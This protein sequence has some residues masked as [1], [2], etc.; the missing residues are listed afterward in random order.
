MNKTLLKNLALLTVSVG[1]ALVVAE[2]AAGMVF[3][4]ITTTTDNRS[5]FALKWKEAN[6]RRNSF[7]YREREF[8]PIKPAGT[9]R[10]AFIGDSYAFGQGIAETDRM[11]NLLEGELR[12]R[13]RSVEVLNF[14]EAGNNTADEV[15]VLQKVLTSVKPDFVLL[16]WF[17]NDTEGNGPTMP[18]AS[19]VTP[20]QPSRF[21]QFK[22]SMRN[23]SVLYFLAAEVWH[24]L[25]ETV[26]ANYAEGIVKRLGDPQSG[27]WQ[28]SE[29]AL[30]EFIQMSREHHVPMGIVLVPSVMPLN[31]QE[32]P[33]AFLHNRVLD[34]CRREAVPCTD[35]LE[36]FKPYMEDRQNYRSLWVNR[37]DSH[38]SELA[39][40][41][42]AEHLFKFFGSS[43]ITPSPAAV[44][45]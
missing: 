29:K 25:L 23:R 36:T 15:R 5:P 45:R 41:L 21:N 9:Y 3:R 37:F 24:R 12:K 31:G 19:S 13:A 6:V 43:L 33:Y 11:S 30:V 22:Q 27:V 14:G 16:Q 2:W 18:G 35:L 8:D 44:A 34:I 32:H 26:A 1:L 28:T 42:A 20:P 39:N 38:M 40:R 10:V 17:V 7:G 4:D